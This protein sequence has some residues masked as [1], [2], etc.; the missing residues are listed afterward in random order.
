[1]HQSPARH[2]RRACVSFGRQ[3]LT[4][5]KRQVSEQRQKITSC[6]RQEQVAADLRPL[7]LL[8]D[9]EVQQVR[10]IRLSRVSERLIP[11][12]VGTT[13]QST[14][15]ATAVNGVWR[16]GYKFLVSGRERACEIDL[17]RG[18]FSLEVSPLNSCRAYRHANFGARSGRRHIK[19]LCVD[20]LRL[21]WNEPRCPFWEE[22]L[23]ASALLDPLAQ[24][25]SVTK[26]YRYITIFIDR[27]NCGQIKVQSGK[28]TSCQQ[29]T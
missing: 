16:E 23:P 2:N 19:E 6:S 4:R 5:T 21:L 1:M 29:T 17:F 9:L 11:S 25:S 18:T 12:E 20:G 8:P 22:N 10:P 15:G 28:T 3:R 24:R 7:A 13:D 26:L 14:G 27:R